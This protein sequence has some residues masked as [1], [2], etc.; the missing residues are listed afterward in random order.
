MILLLLTTC[1]DLRLSMVQNYAGAQAAC[2]K[3]GGQCEDSM[4]TNGGQ[5]LR[6]QGKG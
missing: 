2:K 6:A 4:V 1:I 5:E 3:T